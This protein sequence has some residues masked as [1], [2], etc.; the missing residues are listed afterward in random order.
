MGGAP[1]PWQ[2]GITGHRSKWLAGTTVRLRVSGISTSAGDHLRG[3]DRATRIRASAK[4]LAK[5]MLIG[6]SAPPEAAMGESRGW[7]DIIGFARGHRRDQGRHRPWP[8]D[9][10]PK[11]WL[12]D[13]KS[14]SN[15]EQVEPVPPGPRCLWV[16]SHGALGCRVM[17]YEY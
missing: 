6:R 14:N 9:N 12:N 1:E 8:F 17:Y 2:H 13:W 10:L 4:D 7:N 3:R 16:G 15:N 5:P 11:N